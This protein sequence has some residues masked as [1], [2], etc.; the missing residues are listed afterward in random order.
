MGRRGIWSIDGDQMRELSILY[1]KSW[2]HFAF[3]FIYSKVSKEERR[4][5]YMPHPHEFWVYFLKK[6]HHKRKIN[7][8]SPFIFLHSTVYLP[9]SFNTKI[10]LETSCLQIKLDSLDNTML[11]FSILLA[12]CQDSECGFQI[13]KRIWG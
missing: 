2:F 12:W 13:E 3:Y 5:F 4:I 9:A 7:W 6:D 1:K 11:G 10:I 8:K